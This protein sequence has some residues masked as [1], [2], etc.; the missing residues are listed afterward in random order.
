[1]QE[2]SKIIKMPTTYPFMT[3]KFN[4]IWICRNLIRKKD[5]KKLIWIR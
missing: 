5:Y 4:L 2:I 1:M 3:K